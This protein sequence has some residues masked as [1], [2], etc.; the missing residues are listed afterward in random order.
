M[1]V[2]EYES[3]EQDRATAYRLLSACYYLPQ[4]ETLE[5]LEELEVALVRACPQ[6]AEQIAAMQEAVDLDLLTVDFAQLF[7]GPFK[8]IAPPYGSV[9]L[10]GRREVMGPSTIDAKRRYVEAGLNIAD[11]LNEAPDHIAVELEFVYYLI[12]KEIEAIESGHVDAADEWRHRQQDFLSKHLGAWISDFAA[13]VERGAKT[14]FY[15]S[16]ARATGLFV[17]GDKNALAGSAKASGQSVCVV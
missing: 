11:T 16:L 6:A 10:E 3:T 14:D 4:R 12:Y 2:N 17:V 13:T 9:Y 8:L 1:N 7:V 15:G 5:Q